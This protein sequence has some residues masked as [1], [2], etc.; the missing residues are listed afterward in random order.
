MPARTIRFHVPE[1]APRTDDEIQDEFD[2]LVVRA[3]EGDR[4][5]LTA[6]AIAYSDMLLKEA[7]A[8][9]GRFK[10]DAGDVLADFYLA[11][12]EGEALFDPDKERAGVWMRRIVRELA[13]RY[14]AARARDW[15]IEP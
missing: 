7:R 11:V 15:G 1:N 13:R 5:A 3:C 4:H 12:M 10:Q 6:L 8:E 14:R 9:M 2:D